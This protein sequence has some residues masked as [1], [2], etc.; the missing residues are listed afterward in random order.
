M[1]CGLSVVVLCSVCADPADYRVYSQAS[2]DAV[3]LDA[4]ADDLARRDVVFLGEDHS[5][6]VGH[7]LELESLTALH[8]R[9][10]D[11]VL[12]MEMFERDAQGVLDDYLRDRV[13]EKTF[14]KHARP[15]RDYQKYYRPL[16]EFAK[17]NKLDVVAAN[18]PTLISRRVAKGDSA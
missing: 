1:L 11:V 14:L 18:V 13:D 17:M 10:P 2:G 4:M 9:R 16:I 12:S 5:N 6:P 8:K 15:W 3:A 7:R